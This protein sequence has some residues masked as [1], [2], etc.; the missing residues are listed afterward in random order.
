MLTHFAIG[1]KPYDSSSHLPLGPVVDAD[2]LGWGNARQGQTVQQAPEG[3]ATDGQAQAMAQSCPCRPAP[4][5]G[6]VR[7]PGRELLRPPGS[8]SHDPGPSCDD[9]AAG[10]C[11]VGAEQRPH[12][13]PPPDAIIAPR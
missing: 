9:E 5:Q 10:T 3:V 2:R 11:R 6:E 12:A 13:E 7:Q 4:R 8:G 1:G